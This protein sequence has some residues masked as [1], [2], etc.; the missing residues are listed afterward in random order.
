MAASETQQSG[1]GSDL[2]EILKP[3][4]N[5]ASEAEVSFLFT[6]K[7]ISLQIHVLILSPLCFVC[8]SAIYKQCMNCFR[9]GNMLLCSFIFNGFKDFKRFYFLLIRSV[10]FQVFGIYYRQNWRGSVFRFNL[11][12]SDY[13]LDCVIRRL[14]EIPFFPKWFIFLFFA[15]YLLFSVVLWFYFDRKTYFRELI[16]LLFLSWVCL[17]DI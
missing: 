8:V 13:D 14:N 16:S 9:S 3:F 11:I 6:S 4:Y 12:A 10:K 5:R 15:L 7:L 1:N 2:G 17:Y